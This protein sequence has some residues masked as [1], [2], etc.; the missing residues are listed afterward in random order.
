MINDPEPDTDPILEDNLVNEEVL[1]N[2]AQENPDE[3]R[4]VRGRGQ[5]RR[6]DEIVRARRQ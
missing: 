5:A 2:V 1:P 3:A 6:L 4:V